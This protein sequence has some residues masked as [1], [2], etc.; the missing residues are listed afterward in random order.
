MT[1]RQPFLWLL[2]GGDRRAPAWRGLHR[3]RLRSM[4]NATIATTAPT[5]RPSRSSD[6]EAELRRCWNSSSRS[7][8]QPPRPSNDRT[9]AIAHLH[10]GRR[11]RSRDHRRCRC[12]RA[13]ARQGGDRG[14]SGRPVLGGRA[15]ASGLPDQASGRLY[16]PPGAAELGAA[17][18]R[19][20]HGRRVAS[21]PAP[22]QRAV[23]RPRGGLRFFAV[24]R[25]FSA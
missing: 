11:S 20:G 1:E 16:L 7:T 21:L 15:R 9:P 3:R 14:R 13:L 25:T 19:R 22:A 12:V 6:P 4:A 10:L 5:R 8:I 24:A 23:P 18:A 2:L 17:A